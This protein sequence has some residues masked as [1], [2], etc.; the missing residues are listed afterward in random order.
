[1]QYSR[2]GR[3]VLASYCADY[4]YCFS[5]D[6][7]NG[8]TLPCTGSVP[9]EKS[10]ETGPELPPVKR[11]RLR[12]DWSDTGPQAGPE[13]IAE[14]VNAS[15]LMQQMSALF[16]AF[17]EDAMTS[18]HPGNAGEEVGEREVAEGEEVSERE[19]GVGV[20]E[21]VAESADENQNDDFDS[22]G[23]NSFDV[24]TDL[25]TE[26][27]HNL[28]TDA[29]TEGTRIVGQDQSSIGEGGIT[30]SATNEDESVSNCGGQENNFMVHDDSGYSD[31]ACGSTSTTTHLPEDLE[32]TEPVASMEQNNS[33]SDCPEPELCPESEL[34]RNQAASKIQSFLRR[35][36]TRTSSSGTQHHVDGVHSV[37]SPSSYSVY[38]GHR[39]ARTMIKEANFWG[40]DH[41][42][43]GSDCGRIFIWDRHTGKLVMLLEGKLLFFGFRSA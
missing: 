26:L 23:D 24:S 20:S 13:N 43:S 29:N 12:G 35:N 18:S 17:L 16:S 27:N 8:K 19:L 10:E 39:N 34:S 21:V 30:E 14:T 4:L 42:M 25:D 9:P 6:E 33:N 7:H 28:D 41:V 22:D 2:D 3:D 32:N 1:M 15:N 31:T 37:F 40:D 36:K 5:P 38:K 11:L